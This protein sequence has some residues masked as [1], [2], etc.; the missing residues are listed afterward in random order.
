M[1]RLVG[2]VSVAPQGLPRFFSPRPALRPVSA[3]AASRGAELLHP[4]VWRPVTVL[5]SWLK[6]GES[7]AARLGA[8]QGSGPIASAGLD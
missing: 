7:E 6:V 5:F 1:R 4:G 3:C 8:T 2:A